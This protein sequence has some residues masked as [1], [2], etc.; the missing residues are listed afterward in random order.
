MKRPAISPA[1]RLSVFRDYGAVCL[2]QLCGCVERI[3][4]MDLDHALALIDGGAHETANLRPVCHRCHAV[5]S[6]GEHKS[7]SKAKRLHKA[8]AAHAAVLA[9]EPRQPG[10]I[11]SRGFAGSRRFN[12]EINWRTK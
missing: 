10:K 9:G 11:K 7:N 4:D 6:A 8:R 2:C 5:K 12:G 3:A 1:M